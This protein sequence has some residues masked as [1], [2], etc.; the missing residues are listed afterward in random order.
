MGEFRVRLSVHGACVACVDMG[1]GRCGV[2]TC[3][4]VYVV[5]ALCGQCSGKELYVSACGWEPEVSREAPFEGGC[6]FSL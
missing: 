4:G 1:V 6:V 5:Y 2:H 3:G